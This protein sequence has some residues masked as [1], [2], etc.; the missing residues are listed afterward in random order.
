MSF[1][2]YGN[3]FHHGNE[4]VPIMGKSFPRSIDAL[5]H[6]CIGN[7]F[8]PPPCELWRPVPTTDERD[9]QRESCRRC[10]GICICFFVPTTATR[11]VFPCGSPFA[12][13]K[14][15]RAYQW[16]GAKSARSEPSRTPPATGRTT[17]WTVACW[18]SLTKHGLHV[19][20]GR[21]NSFALNNQGTSCTFH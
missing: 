7:E 19:Q 9:P 11:P 14:C 20:S 4:L 5:E 13:M 18:C 17:K 1:S 15:M 10:N 16:S 21:T 12:C 8:R 2:H 3:E 6:R